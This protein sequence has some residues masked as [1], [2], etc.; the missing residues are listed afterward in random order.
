MKGLK[1]VFVLLL[2][3]LLVFSLAACDINNNEQSQLNKITTPTEST[4]PT[5]DSTLTEPTVTEPITT[6][7]EATKPTESEVQTNEDVMQPYIKYED[8][9]KDNDYLQ[10]VMNNMR[11]HIGTITVR[12]TDFL[13]ES[14]KIDFQNKW[15]LDY[16]SGQTWS[17]D[18]NKNTICVLGKEEYATEYGQSIESCALINKLDQYDYVKV[19][20]VLYGANKTVTYSTLIKI[21]LNED[22][23]IQ[24]Y[25]KSSLVQYEEWNQNWN[26]SSLFNIDETIYEYSAKSLF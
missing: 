24:S 20:N 5:E 17:I 22:G 23:T 21:Y 19:G 2:A 13:N 10:T 26:D 11:N 12:K 9:G 14:T 16:S 3:C 6:Q 18:F 25:V 1:K 8:F 7:P 4:S 15:V